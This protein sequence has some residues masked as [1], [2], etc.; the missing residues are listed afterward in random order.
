MKPGVLQ[1]AFRASVSRTLAYLS[2][3]GM[4]PA[5]APLSDRTALLTLLAAYAISAVAMFGVTQIEV[6]IG[7]DFAA[8]DMMLQGRVLYRDIE[9]WFG[10]FAPSLH[11]LLFRVFGVSLQVIFGA[12]IAAGLAIA[13]LTYWLAREI[14]PPLEGLIC[15]L[16]VVTHG[17]FGGSIMN[18]AAPYTYSATYGL[19][20]ALFA[21]LA[22]T[23]YLRAAEPR[24]GLLAGAAA[25]VALLCKQEFGLIS[26]GLLGAGILVAPQLRGIGLLRRAA[27]PIAAYLA[28]VAVASMMLFWFVAPAEF[29]ANYFPAESIKALRYF[30]ANSQGWGPRAPEFLLRTHGLFLL[31]VGF[32]VALTA[33]LALGVGVLR[34]GRPKFP[35][36]AA[37]VACAAPLIWARGYLWCYPPL[38]SLAV[39]AYAW[40]APE[41]AGRRNVMLFGGV[42]LLFGWRV[43]PNFDTRYYAPMYFV[44]AVIVYVYLLFEIVVPRLAAALPGRAWRGAM[45][46]SLIGPFVIYQF[47]QNNWRIARESAPIETARGTVRIPAERAPATRALIEVIEAHSEPGDGILAIPGGVMY[48]FLTGRRPA[49]RY[50]DYVYA[51][52]I[53]G[54]RE[55]EEI[56]RLE[57]NP[58]K[59]VFISPH[60]N[61]AYLPQNTDGRFGVAYNRGLY[62]WIAGRYRD[63]DGLPRALEGFRVMAPIAS[64]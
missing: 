35:T 27:P 14:L 55:A 34:G 19:T 11:Y 50:L 49:S 25:G 44:P 17:V 16:I 5:G 54:E 23:R 61:L 56:R 8:P 3:R 22:V 37:I 52:L 12:G 48:C 6:D 47:V 60:D 64:P 53:D 29:V 31:N 15:G 39:M 7:R 33:V 21:F 36:A 2:Y 1:Q 18:H 58:P 51:T 38:L 42:A 10:P 43:L 4:M 45:A 28:I 9:Y 40:R 20:F 63:V 59:L 13:V 41:L 26:V 57:A 32:V 30:Y 46:A 62:E 24:W